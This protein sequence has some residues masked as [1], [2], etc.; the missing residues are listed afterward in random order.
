MELTLEEVAVL[1]KS[2]GL[3][4]D[5]E[6]LQDVTYRLNALLFDMENIDIPNLDKVDP[7]LCCKLNEANNG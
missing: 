6:D 5:S 4:I 2:V 1:A 7:F 3:R